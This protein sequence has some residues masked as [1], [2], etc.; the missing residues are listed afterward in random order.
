MA[1]APEVRGASLRELAAGVA[2][3]TWKSRD[4][5][6]AYL[7]RIKRLD[8]KLG[9]FLLVDEAGARKAADAIDRKVAAGDSVGP[10]AGVQ[11]GRAH[12]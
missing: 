11:I 5:V 10:L 1:G 2:A 12:V 6:D 9:C 7:D 4:L 3:R 8:E